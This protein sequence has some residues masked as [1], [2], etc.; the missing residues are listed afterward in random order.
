MKSNTVNNFKVY[1]GNSPNFFFDPPVG[2]KNLVTTMNYYAWFIRR[3]FLSL[4]NPL[5]SILC[6]PP[7]TV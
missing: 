3:T 7:K 6:V 1:N 4:C 2:K 5:S